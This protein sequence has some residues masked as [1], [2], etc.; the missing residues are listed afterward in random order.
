MERHRACTGTRCGRKGGSTGTARSARCPA[1]GGT[2][3]R[4]AL[5]RAARRFGGKERFSPPFGGKAVP[6]RATAGRFARSA[7]LLVAALA[8]GIA[9]LAASPHEANAAAVPS[10]GAKAH[11]SCYIE[12]SWR[13]NG[14]TYFNAGGFSGD[15]SG[16]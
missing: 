15:L 4:E 13:T 12:N 1:R 16:A 9:L 2:R 5:A 3:R 11:G 8:L 10:I 6:L 14:Q 7:F